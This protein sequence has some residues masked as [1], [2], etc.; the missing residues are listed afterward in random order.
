[1]NERKK[2]ISPKKPFGSKSFSQDTDIYPFKPFKWV[3]MRAYPCENV[4]PFKKKIKEKKSPR[5]FQKEVVWGI[6][7]NRRS[8]KNKIKISLIERKIR[9]PVFRV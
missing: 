7:R 4:S 2:W 6:W 1:M 3:L 8:K 9:K 5:H